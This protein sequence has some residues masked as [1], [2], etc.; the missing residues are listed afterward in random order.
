MTTPCLFLYVHVDYNPGGGQ[1][2][3]QA[4]P[5]QISYPATTAASK[6]KILDDDEEE[7]NPGQAQQQNDFG[8]KPNYGAEED[9]YKTAYETYQEPSKQAEPVSSKLR[10]DEDY[11]GTGTFEYKP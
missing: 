6:S 5:E 1:S 9:T 3:Y 2:E 8:Y 7:Y 10:F 4:Q 11:E